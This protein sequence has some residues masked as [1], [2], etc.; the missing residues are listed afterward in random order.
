MDTSAPFLIESVSIESNENFN[1]VKVRV[2]TFEG[3]GLD[4]R[5][6]NCNLWDQILCSN[7]FSNSCGDFMGLWPIVLPNLTQN[8]EVFLPSNPRGKNLRFWDQSQSS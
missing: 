2:Q 5:T 1:R 4:P 6:R 8:K 7:P 3:E